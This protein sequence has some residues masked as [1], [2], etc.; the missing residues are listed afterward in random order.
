M[1]S[2]TTDVRFVVVLAFILGLSARPLMRCVCFATSITFTTRVPPVGVVED[3][4][5]AGFEVE[6]CSLWLTTPSGPT[7]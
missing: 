4:G 7:A 6:V 2:I 5:F 3:Q 1:T